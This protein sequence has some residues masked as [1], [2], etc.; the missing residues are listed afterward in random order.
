MDDEVTMVPLDDDELKQVEIVEVMLELINSM[1]E[2]E[3]ELIDI[4]VED[5]GGDEEALFEIALLMTINE[6]DEE[7]DM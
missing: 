3:V 7:A 6:L 5:D 2:M 1:D 4:E